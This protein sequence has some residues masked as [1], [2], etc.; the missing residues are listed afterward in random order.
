MLPHGCVRVEKGALRCCLHDFNKC[1]WFYAITAHSFILLFAIFSFGGERKIFITHFHAS[2]CF[3]IFYTA[4]TQI[5]IKLRKRIEDLCKR[6]HKKRK[7]EGKFHLTLEDV[8]S[9]SRFSAA[10]CGKEEA[11]KNCQVLMETN[12]SCCG[13]WKRKR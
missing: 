11:Q 4:H 8:F 9:A 2:V 1:D 7:E 3:R 13:V 6:A 12:K 10:P 5:Q